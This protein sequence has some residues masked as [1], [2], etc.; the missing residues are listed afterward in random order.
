[1]TVRDTRTREDPSRL[2]G[3][4]LSASVG[5]PVGNPEAVTAGRQRSSRRQRIIRALLPAEASGAGEIRALDG[6][7]AIAALSI[8][9]FHTLLYL[10]I[11]YL[12]ASQATGSVWYYLS[13][14]VQLFFVLS[15]FLL[16]RP[17]AR[18][19]LSGVALPSWARFYQRRALRILP[20]YWAALA[21]MFATQWTTANQPLWLNALAHITL[22]HDSFPRFNRSLDGPFWTLAV[23][24]QFYL[25]LP[26]IAA[27]MAW[28]MRGSRSAARLIG[29]LL[30]VIALAEVL[31]WLDT[32]LMASVTPNALAHG[33]GEAARF[34]L[35]LAT[36]GMQGKNLEVFFVGAL[37]ATVYVIA[38]EREGLARHTQRRVARWLLGLGAVLS[39]AAAPAWELG[40]VMFTPGVQWG[41]R[42]ITYPL[43]V[44]L[45]FGLMTLGI[46]WGGPLVRGIFTAAPLRFVGLISYSMYVWH[47]PIL[48]GDL[49][50]FAHMPLW[51]RLVCVLVVSYLSYQL[52]ERPFLRRRQR[53]HKSAPERP[54]EQPTPAGQRQS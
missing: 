14:G 20:V 41:L 26:V 24:V 25:L 52:L 4:V 43:I 28:V 53:L 30:G 12:P 47:L 21:V 39:I 54:R 33:G 34:I 40:A 8:V 7:R 44:G 51:L 22:T 17:Y 37:C 23:E 27:G 42:I 18:A 31:R 13:M 36:M 32:L 11:E 49:P 2:E 6:V 19:I 15:G 5:N 48:H 46:V 3:S 29:A 50:L 9:I 10:K 1:M 35:A 16:F 45:S 38:T